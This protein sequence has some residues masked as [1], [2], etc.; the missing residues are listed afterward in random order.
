MSVPAHARAARDE[1]GD[2]LGSLR[3][4]SLGLCG[5]LPLERKASTHEEAQRYE[6]TEGG[7]VRRELPG[8]VFHQEI[9]EVS[10][11]M[12]MVNGQDRTRH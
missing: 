5:P 8:G 9:T 11:G 10:D 7:L 3:A 6:L 2:G 12:V 1:G 4:S